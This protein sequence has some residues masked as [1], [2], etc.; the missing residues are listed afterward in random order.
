[1]RKDDRLVYHRDG[2]TPRLIAKGGPEG[3]TLDFRP[4]GARIDL[5]G[6]GGRDNL[7]GG[8]GDDRLDGGAD[9][10]TYSGGTGRDVIFSRDGVGE[11]VACGLGRD[12]VTADSNDSLSSCETRR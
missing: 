6:G 1:M 7:D 3:D 11:S 2:P 12:T 5:D 9:K 8:R 4:S 10:D